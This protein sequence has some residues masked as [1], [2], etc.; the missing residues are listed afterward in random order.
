METCRHLA[1]GSHYTRTDYS[2]E[3]VAVCNRTLRTKT[4]DSPFTTAPRFAAGEALDLALAND[5]FGIVYSMGFLH[6]TP[7]PQRAASEVHRVLKPGGT[8]HAFLYR[9]FSVKVG[10]A[11]ILRGM[12]R[13]LDAVLR[14]ERVI[15]SLFLDGTQ[16]SRTLGT[17]LHECFGAPYMYS[18]TR[19]EAETRSMPSP[20]LT[21]SL[22]V[23]TSSRAARST[24]KARSA[25]FTA[26]K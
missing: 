23:S 12:Q 9:T 8:C 20:R 13:A 7:D 25:T 22:S 26:T 16:P 3:S 14:R 2:T 24:A 6:H 19:G 11:K 21:S 10:A 17:M 4:G 1:P 18:Y 15:Y 5:R